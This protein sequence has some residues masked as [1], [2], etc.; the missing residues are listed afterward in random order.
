[1]QNERT[2]HCRARAIILTILHILC[3]VGPLLYFI[4]FGFL[5]GTIVSKVALSFSLII[6]IILAAISLIVGI[7]HR[8]GLHRGIMWLL[9]GGIL[10]CLEAVKPFIWIMAG[11]SIFDEL[12]LVPLKE[13]YSAAY[14]TNKEID[15]RE[16]KNKIVKQEEK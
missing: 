6:S 5:T 3:L 12:L 4:P 13:H 14:K 8:A 11:I 16:P 1:M 10:F 7:K 2:K 15:L 9:I